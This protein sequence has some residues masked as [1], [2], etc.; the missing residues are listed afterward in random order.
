MWGYIVTH[1]KVGNLYEKRYLE[2]D[3]S[4]REVCAA[5][6][7]HNG[8]FRMP[9]SAVTVDSTA[10]NPS[11]YL[12]KPGDRVMISLISYQLKINWWKEMVKKKKKSLNYL[13]QSDL[14][15]LDVKNIYW[16]AFKNRTF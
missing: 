7:L 5:I 8:I 14:F 13:H 15:G 2:N 6:S 16:K 12:P 4:I 1:Y 3:G 11:L 9:R 10:W